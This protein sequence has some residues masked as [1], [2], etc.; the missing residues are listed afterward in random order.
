MDHIKKTTY[1]KC[2]NNLSSWVKTKL[3]GVI[4][5]YMGKYVGRD[6]DDITTHEKIVIISYSHDE[7]YD[8]SEMIDK[9]QLYQ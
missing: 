7:F 1:Q 9:D 2:T 6:K 5:L 3:A 4:K 8:N